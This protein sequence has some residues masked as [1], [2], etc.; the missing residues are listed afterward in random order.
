MAN[1]PKPNIVQLSQAKRQKTIEAAN[2]L[3]IDL[4]TDFCAVRVKRWVDLR[5]N[6]GDLTN[7]CAS[8]CG[9]CRV[10][11]LANLFFG[12]TACVCILL[13]IKV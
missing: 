3:V 8:L 9:I 2:A 5:C 7:W 11:S 12:Y 10:A 1:C 6:L 4:I 13:R